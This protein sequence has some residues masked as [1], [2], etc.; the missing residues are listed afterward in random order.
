[1]AT[2]CLDK[3]YCENAWDCNITILDTEGNPI[4]PLL[5]EDY[6]NVVI[7]LGE[8]PGYTFSGFVDENGE[9]VPSIVSSVT[10]NAYEL[11]GVMCD[12]QY[13]AKYCR[14]IYTIGQTSASSACF[15]GQTQYTNAYYGDI[16]TITARENYKCRFLYWKANNEIVSREKS[17]NHVVTGNITFTA[18]YDSI[19]YRITAKPY[20]ASI[21]YCTGSG[22]YNLGQTATIHALTFSSSYIFSGW[23]DGNY[24]NPRTITVNGNATYI[25]NFT[26]QAIKITVPQSTGGNVIGSGD[27]KSGNV[28]TLQA[29]SEPGWRFSHWLV[30]GAEYTNETYRFVANENKSVIPFFVPQT[31]TLTLES[32]PFGT[33]SFTVSPQGSYE[34]GDTVLITAVPT[35]GYV[36]VEWN[37]GVTNPERSVTFYSN[38]GL[39]AI[40]E[41]QKTLHTI[42]VVLPDS[43]Y[44]CYVYYNGEDIGYKSGSNITVSA[45]EGSSLTITPIIPNGK[46]LISVTDSDNN[47]IWQ[48]TAYDSRQQSIIYVVGDSDETLTLNFEDVLYRMDVAFEPVNTGLLGYVDLTVSINGNVTQFTPTQAELVRRFSNLGYGDEISL[49]APL[50]VGTTP[51]LFWDTDLGSIGTN[52]M[53]Y[54]LTKD[55]KCVAIFG[56]PYDAYDFYVLFAKIT[57]NNGTYYVNVNGTDVEYNSLTTQQL[58]SMAITEDGRTASDGYLVRSSANKQ[59][60]NLHDGNSM[61]CDYVIHSNDVPEHMNAV[62]VMYRTSGTETPY[63]NK[64]AWNGSLDNGYYFNSNTNVDDLKLYLQRTNVVY[65]ASTYEIKGWYSQLIDTFDV[66]FAFNFYQKNG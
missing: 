54:Q 36:F 47:V 37:D 64:F 57:Y 16:I 25:A 31:Y 3:I 2:T 52:V 55:M 51:F 5:I 8:K 29:V 22:N 62:L 48:N 44:N 21:G 65:G 30:D 11:Q 63:L 14:I 58:L 35:Y 4:D 59:I 40:F 1:M 18:Y 7:V 9:T 20:D 17:F 6:S 12:K 66:D 39:K 23:D 10:E 53:N 26:A 33:G 42:T 15:G 27:Y 56:E 46:R 43:T 50:N 13:F 34:Y 38:V 61:E 49:T 41:E 28:I 19:Q 60:F 32:V 24:D 45:T